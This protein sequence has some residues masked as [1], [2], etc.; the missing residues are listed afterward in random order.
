[1]A[2]LTRPRC[3][4]SREGKAPTWTRA[5]GLFDPGAAPTRSA[6]SAAA[7]I[8]VV[9]GGWAIKGAIEAAGG[10][11]AGGGA[12]EAGGAT[13]GSADAMTGPVWFDPALPVSAGGT[14]AVGA[15]TATAAESPLAG[16]AG[17]LSS[18]AAGAALSASTPAGAG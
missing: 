13:G 6:G 7:A 9:A 3:A 16:A 1:L 17:P 12:D 2:T 11:G 15:L 18:L 4:S 10:G 5:R 14:S 8:D